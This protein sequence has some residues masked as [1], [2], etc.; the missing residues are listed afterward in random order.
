MEQNFQK[1]WTRK[2]NEFV[3]KLDGHPLLN[4]CE[5]YLGTPNSNSI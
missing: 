1:E 3:N 4:T 2:C 5:V